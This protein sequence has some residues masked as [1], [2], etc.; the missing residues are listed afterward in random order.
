MRR[1]ATSFV[2]YGT[3]CILIATLGLILA[4]FAYAD[5]TLQE[6]VVT[7]SRQGAQSIQSIPMSITAINPSKS[8]AATLSDLATLVPS[9]N[10]EQSSPG[11]S[12]VDIRG[13]TT[14][15]ADIVN[16]LEDR[17]LVGVY[18]DETPIAM[19]GFNPDL[20]VF[21][22]D[23]VEVL[24]GPQGTLYG[25]GSMGG[26]VRYITTK[27]SPLGF[28]GSQELT[29][30]DT[31]GG[32]LN[33]GVRGSVNLPTSLSS[34]L[35]LT[36]YTGRNS[37]WID[38]TELNSA[39]EN[40]DRSSQARIAYRI[41]EGNLT[42]DVS[43]LLERLDTG[44][45]D[46]TFSQL[47]KSTY[48]SLTPT[49]VNDDMKV[50]NVTVEDDVALGNI[51]SSTSFINRETGFND[52]GQYL[53]EDFFSL[54]A[55]ATPYINQNAVTQF[56]QETRLISN[57]SW[58]K[59]MTG[60]YYNHMVRKDYQDDN[61]PGFDQAIGINSLAYG[62]FHPNSVFSGDEYIWEHEIGVFGQLTQTV[63]KLDFSEGVRYFDWDQ[64]FYLY[65]AGIGASYDG[66][67]HPATLDNATSAVGVNPKFT[68]DYHLNETTF[69]FLE[70]AKGFRY[71]G[72][73]QYVPLS[74]CGQS[75][76]VTYGPDHLWSYSLGEKTTLGSLRLNAT[77]YL[78][79][80]SNVQTEHE[81]ACSYA[82]TQ[83]AGAVQS[84]GTELEASYSL[85]HFTLALNG[86]YT[87]AVSDGTLPNVNALSGE[88]TPYTPRWLSA[89]T[90]SYTQGV[91]TLASVYSYHGQSY[92]TFNP[93]DPFYRTLPAYSNLDLR[94]D[95]IKASW[96]LGA[97]IKNAMNH[98][99][100]TM[101]APDALNGVQP[102]DEV[103]YARPRTIGVSVM[104]SF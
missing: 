32:G 61:G 22:I 33:Y 86:S 81:L 53:S 90:L 25:A 14:G 80:W 12:K 5:D 54:P 37:G 102:G 20:H 100:V 10:L 101:I 39:H 91:W 28:S 60:V 36:G 74:V 4:T 82:Y 34:A 17:P 42:I 38:N 3:L 23:R 88:Q 46:Y 71:G 6:V 24:R 41:M 56:T 40:W 18:L 47:G 75:A 13:V 19:Q 76:P 67:G 27:P 83:N 97:F 29:L 59:W 70:A 1:F 98:G 64:N 69:L 11:L 103:A 77:A 99:E 52:T 2:R 79:R 15:A 43:A 49:P 35:L 58:F 55:M 85:N 96:K 104:R 51:V 7:A 16:N 57:D 72:V 31:V 93:L 73:N 89:S 95:Y 87:K 50:F 84:T 21:D 78:I 92:T 44:G 26:T 68:A 30:S 66:P 94:L 45:S 65:F 8:D 63:G 62:A 9:L 48:Y